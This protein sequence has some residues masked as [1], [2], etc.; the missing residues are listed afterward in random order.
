MEDLKPIVLVM[1]GVF[2]LLFMNLQRSKHFNVYDFP[3]IIGRYIL[4]PFAQ[5]Y[6]NEE[7]D[8]KSERLYFCVGA[9]VFCGVIFL[10]LF[11]TSIIIKG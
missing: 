4:N 9:L 11:L 2:F 6:K 1:I 5:I 7:Y 8:P 3:R 10:I